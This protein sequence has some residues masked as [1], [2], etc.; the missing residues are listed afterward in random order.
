MRGILSGTLPVSIFG[1][2]TNV[3]RRRDRFIPAGSISYG[4]N[5][6][7]KKVLPVLVKKKIG[8]LG[9]KPMGAGLILNTRR[10]RRSTVCTTR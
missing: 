9:T 10:W 6:F 5:S 2:I 7:G 3:H 1:V 4:D 8:V